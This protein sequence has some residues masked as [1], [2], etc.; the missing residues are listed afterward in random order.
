M[1]VGIVIVLRLRDHHDSVERIQ[2]A[3][4]LL[5]KS[6]SRFSSSFSP[7][8]KV[9]AGAR[10]LQFRCEESAYP[11]AQNVSIQLRRDILAGILTVMFVGGVGS[12]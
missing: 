6:C 4:M 10:S 2:D 11:S 8:R 9:A 5:F 12:R 3:L 7:L 1:C